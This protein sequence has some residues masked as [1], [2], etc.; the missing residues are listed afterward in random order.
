MVIDRVLEVLTSV[1]M[2]RFITQQSLNPE[3]IEK[4][5]GIVVFDDNQKNS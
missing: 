4:Q 3:L 2:S 1:M 5:H